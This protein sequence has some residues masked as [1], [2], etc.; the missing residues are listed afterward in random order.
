MDPRKDAAL[1]PGLSFF[2][3]I[4]DHSIWQGGRRLF[5]LLPGKNFFD[6]FRD[7]PLL[8]AAT[9]DVALCTGGFLKRRNAPES[10]T[11]NRGKRTA[12]PHTLAEVSPVGI[13]PYRRG[14]FHHLRESPLAPDIRHHVRKSYGQRGLVQ[15]VHP[16]DRDMLRR[17]WE[18]ATCHQRV[19]RI[20]D[21]VLSAHSSMARVIGQAIPEPGC[22][23]RPSY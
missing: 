21:T 5:I 11:G 22:G 18:E 17:N 6:D 4:T 3:V 13:F 20:R 8:E 23:Q 7:R 14:R 16:D 12:L 1:E 15:R 9:G 19:S 2:D 10:G